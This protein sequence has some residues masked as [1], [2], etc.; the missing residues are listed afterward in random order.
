M[1][2]GSIRSGH[3]AVFRSRSL[4]PVGTDDRGSGLRSDT[5]KAALSVTGLNDEEKFRP[6]RQHTR[7]GGF[8]LGRGFIVV[9]GDSCYVAAVV[10]R[11]EDAVGLPSRAVG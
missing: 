6:E 2:N 1:L 8:P 3:R 5:K 11:P 10:V 4:E 7:C 9:D